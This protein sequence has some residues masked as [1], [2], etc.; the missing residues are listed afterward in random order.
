M[1]QPSAL[2]L[3]QWVGLLPAVFWNRAKDHYIYGVDFL[4]ATLTATT[5]AQLQINSDADFACYGLSASFFGV[6]N[7][8]FLAAPVLTL[9]IADAGSGRF[10]SNQQIHVMNWIGQVGGTDAAGIYL[11]VKPK[12]VGG[13]STLTLS[14][15]NLSG[16]SYNVRLAFH[17]LKIY[18]FPEQGYYNPLPMVNS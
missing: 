9:Q 14:M 17:G 13:G 12:I 16:T 10:W 2:M 1:P 5:N 4:P 3:N 7:T 8:T 11:F 15:T 6:D 18:P